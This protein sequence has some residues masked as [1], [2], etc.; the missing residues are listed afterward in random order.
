ML[1]QIKIDVN[2]VNVILDIASSLNDI[3]RAALADV[4]L[5]ADSDN[6][7]EYISS[8]EYSVKPKVPAPRGLSGRRVRANERIFEVADKLEYDEPKRMNDEL[9]Y[10]DTFELLSKAALENISASASRRHPELIVRLNEALNKTLSVDIECQ[11]LA[12]KRIYNSIVTRLEL[13]LKALSVKDEM[14]PSQLLT[15]I[16]VIDNYLDGLINLAKEVKTIPDILRD[17]LK[18]AL[19]YFNRIKQAPINSRFPHD[20]HPCAVWAWYLADWHGYKNFAG[21][22]AFH[23]DLFDAKGIPLTLRNIY[24]PGTFKIPDSKPWNINDNKYFLTATSPMMILTKADEPG[25]FIVEKMQ[26]QRL[27]EPA[28]FKGKRV[29]AMKKHLIYGTNS[30]TD[31]LLILDRNPITK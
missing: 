29:R 9:T 23:L 19:A 20:A 5:H 8:F 13:N 26:E 15:E 21:V 17:R 10:M 31:A 2:V 24:K 18:R 22:F 1:K 11:E 12:F 30:I 6:L 25:Y 7:R 27:Y 4:I 3:Q 16:R 14:I 28:M